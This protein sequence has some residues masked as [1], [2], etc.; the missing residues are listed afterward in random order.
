[1]GVGGDGGGEGPRMARGLV[2]Q[3]LTRGA[4][5]LRENMALLSTG[6]FPE[7]L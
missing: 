3:C 4:G 2:G 1:M 6:R 5:S 7:K